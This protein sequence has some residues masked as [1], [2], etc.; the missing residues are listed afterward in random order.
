MKYCR[1]TPS[2]LALVSTHRCERIN[3]S[4]FVEILQSNTKMMQTTLELIFNSSFTFS[5]PAWIV[6]IAV[7]FA[8]C[9]LYWDKNLSRLRMNGKPES[10]NVSHNAFEI[11]WQRPM[12]ARPTSYSVYVRKASE[13][14]RWKIFNS[15]NGEC[16][17]KISDLPPIQNML[18]VCV[19]TEEQKLDL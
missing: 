12:F 8:C 10:F 16:F 19:R 6:F 9:L 14:E 5:I 13:S 4:V 7:I 3:I 11:R 1:A 15:R 2:L 17:I 18:Y